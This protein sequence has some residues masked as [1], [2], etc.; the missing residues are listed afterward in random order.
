MKQRLLALALL[1]V[2]LPIV[3]FTFGC[4]GKASAPVPTASPTELHTG[5]ADTSQGSNIA[6]NQLQKL[7]KQIAASP[8][9]LALTKDLADTY[10]IRATNGDK[11]SSSMDVRQAANYYESWLA[12]QKA[13]KGATAR[14]ARADVLLSLA[15]AYVTMNNWAKTNNTYDRLTQLYPNNPDYFLMW[16][17]AA[18]T[19]SDNSAAILVFDRYLVLVPHGADSAAIRDWISKNS[20]K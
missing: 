18:L 14:Q 1:L 6:E 16:G 13:Q 19:A 20:G 4:G 9:N 17:Q 7:K 8:N 15:T 3:Q 11:A 10:Q 5:S 12:K 2:A